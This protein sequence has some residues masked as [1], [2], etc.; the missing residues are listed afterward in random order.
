MTT[1]EKI[2]EDLIRQ[3]QSV[4]SMKID[5]CRQ[6]AERLLNVLDYHDVIALIDEVHYAQF[7]QG[8]IAT[9]LTTQQQVRK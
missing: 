2:I 5:Q 9:H 4:R 3:Q 6:L 1:M 8:E 7:A